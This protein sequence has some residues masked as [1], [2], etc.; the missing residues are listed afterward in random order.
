VSQAALVFDE[1]NGGY[2]KPNGGG[3]NS[4]NQQKLHSV[5]PVVAMSIEDPLR[6]NASVAK[7]AQNS[8][9]SCNG[10]RSL[11]SA[12]DGEMSRSADL[13]RH[14]AEMRAA[15]CSAAPVLSG[16]GDPGDRAQR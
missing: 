15:Q 3:S 12:V 6:R 14:F 10:N 13:D 8:A 9:K 4:W 11:E 5:L 7:C 1:A 16:N 2:L